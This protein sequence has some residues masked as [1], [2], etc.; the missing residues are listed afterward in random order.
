MAKNQVSDVMVNMK[1]P[2]SII[3]YFIGIIKN[4]ASWIH[5]KMK[6]KKKPLFLKK[7]YIFLFFFLIV[8]SMWN[9]LRTCVRHVVC[10]C[11][12]LCSVVCCCVLLYAVVCC[13]ILLCAVVSCCVLLYTVV[14]CCVQC[15]V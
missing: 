6:P 14:C 10:S 4:I 3:K 5:K 8:K 2:I 1:A 13:C 9:H 7:A 11:M 12:M 15:L